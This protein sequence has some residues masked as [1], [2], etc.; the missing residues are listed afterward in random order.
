MATR[1]KYE[2]N[3][4]LNNT[5]TERKPY[6]TLQAANGAKNAASML[7]SAFGQGAAVTVQVPQ[8][9]AAQGATRYADSVAQRNQFLQS[10]GYDITGTPVSVPSTSGSG[11]SGGNYTQPVR[12]VGDYNWDDGSSLLTPDNP[13]IQPVVYNNEFSPQ[14]TMLT[15]NDIYGEY[16]APIVE[17]QQ[18]KNTKAYNDA[19]VRASAQMGAYGMS[20]GSAGAQQLRMQATREAEETNLAYQQ[21]MQLQA[22]QDTIN[23]RELELQNKIQDYQNAWQEVAMYGYVVTDGAGKLLG[24]QPG[25]QLT[26]TAYKTAMSNIYQNVANINAAKEELALQ[27][28]ELDQAWAKFQ[29]NIR[30][31]DLG[32]DLSKQELEISKQNSKVQNNQYLYQRLTDMLQ[33]YDTVT[34][35]MVLLGA[36]VG[37]NMKI[38][39][40]TVNY[41][42]E[43][44]RYANNQSSYGNQQFVNSYQLQQ[45]TNSYMPYAQSSGKIGN[46]SKFAN[47]LA[48]WKTEGVSAEQAAK[49][50][51]NNN[52]QVT[53]SDG[54]TYNIKDIIGQV[55]GSRD[56]AKEAIYNVLG[57]EQ[58]QQDYQNELNRNFALQKVNTAG[59]LASGAIGMATGG[60]TM[61]IPSLIN[62][63]LGAY[64]TYKTNTMYR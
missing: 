15:A 54:Q 13:L 37:M 20:S 6:T 49:I 55:N 23:A 60:P 33:R 21:Q 7:P 39:D 30:Q 14:S 2:Y 53:L 52:S 12:N 47:L 32:Y 27:Q 46:T 31:F 22:F 24:I 18:A 57:T 45:L 62:L 19:A 64:N 9:A 36:Q 44:E 5:Q 11:S 43:A 1:K 40:P 41:L 61:F 56:A 25:Q 35:D 29:E 28:Q 16:Y 8:T 63:G 10:Q 38:G 34:P 17:Q 4:A 42:T 51:T 26:T 3:N 59:Q 58:Q 50:V 48:I